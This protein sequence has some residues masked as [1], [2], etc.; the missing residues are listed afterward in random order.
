MSNLT[1]R[2]QKEKII[3]AYLTYHYARKIV[4]FS[5]RVEYTF[6][7]AFPKTR[8]ET[9][10][11]AYRAATTCPSFKEKLNVMKLKSFPTN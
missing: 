2:E 11:K 5:D 10:D 8:V 4:F 7:E 9:L 6:D 3:R 1:E